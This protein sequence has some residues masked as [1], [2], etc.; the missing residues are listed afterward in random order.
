MAPT[1]C[2]T[3]ARLYDDGDRVSI[4]RLDLT[5]C[6]RTRP[7]DIMKWA[8]QKQPWLFPHRPR[9]GRPAFPPPTIDDGIPDLTGHG[10]TPLED[11]V[12]KALSRY[13]DI[14]RMDERRKLALLGKIER[15]AHWAKQHLAEDGE[16]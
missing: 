9:H 8:K 7:T 4:R 3:L 6:K 5:E 10:P 13:G 2:M 1:A 14:E 12:L 16:G 15:L 11:C